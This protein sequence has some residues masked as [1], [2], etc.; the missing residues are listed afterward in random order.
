MELFLIYLLKASGILTLFYFAHQ[1]F[2]KKETFFTINRHFLIIG[3]LLS[4]LLP[5]ITIPNYVEITPISFNANDMAN[6]NKTVVTTVPQIKWASILFLV[7]I[8]GVIILA[9]RF[10]VQLISLY[11]L[12]NGNHIKKQ[13]R[14]YQ[15]EVQ[16]DISPFSFFNYIFY[17]PKL[18]SKKELVAIIEHEK[19]HSSQWHSIDVIVSHLITICTWMNP[20]SWLYQ[21]NIKQNLEFLADESAT[22]EISSIKTYQYTLLKVSGNSFCT[23]IVNNFYNSLIKKRIVMLNK[24]KS[25]K[26]NILKIALVLP[27]LALFLASFNTRDIYIPINNR[28]DIYSDENVRSNIIEITI[29]KNTTDKELEEIRKDL[30]NKGIDFSYTV[31]HNPNKEIIDISIDFASKKKDGKN[32][33]SSSNF[34]NGDDPIDPIHIIYDQESNS[35]SMGSNKGVHMNIHKDKDVHLDVQVEAHEETEHSIWIHSDDDG[36]EHKTIEIIDENGKETIKVNG[37]KLTRKQLKKMKKKDDVHERHIKIK[38]HKE[39][40]KHVYIMKDSDHDGD[41][42]IEVISKKTN[43]F[44]FIDS[45]EDEKPIFIIDG[46]ESKEY[47]VKLIDPTNIKSINVRKGESAKE[48]YDKKGENGVIELTTKKIKPN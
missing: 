17:N 41:M 9:F 15:V 34:Y 6:D 31:V 36:D 32:R 28:I 42:D 27:A 3:I 33:R 11:K 38:K 44:F 26:K 29:D 35:I 2:L 45:D 5:F 20:F 4:A 13:G 10:I 16:S 40:D 18:Y 48:K 24:S 12:T 14:F 46:Q 30:A 25:G 47:K 37:K 21:T 43:G 8:I 23:P 19:A 22:K 1:F 7:Y 39:D